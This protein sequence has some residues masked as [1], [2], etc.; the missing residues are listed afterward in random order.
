MKI[1]KL[2]KKRALPSLCTSNLDVLK[3]AIYF[4][5]KKN[6][7]ILIESTSSQVNHQGPYSGK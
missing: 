6:F 5:K 7:P 1:D 3:T 2:I 4:C